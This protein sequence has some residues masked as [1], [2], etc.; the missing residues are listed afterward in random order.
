MNEKKFSEI[1]TKK[2][3]ELELICAPLKSDSTPGQM[4]IELALDKTRELYLWMAEHLNEKT[5]SLPEV[6]P[7]KKEIPQKEVEKPEAIAK[8][9]KKNIPYIDV[10]KSSPTT[11]QPAKQNITEMEPEEAPEIN[12]EDD[13]GFVTA[14]E[15]EPPLRETKKG[16][17]ATIGDKFQNNEKNFV[18]ENLGKN[19]ENKDL[20]SRLQA[21]PITD[22]RASIGINEKFLF[23]KEL[24]KGNSD[25][26]SKSIDFLNQAGSI[27]NAMQYIH[28]NFQWD[29]ESETTIKFLDLVNRKF[30]R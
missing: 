26:Y 25:Y 5:D 1:L 8:E 22:L 13:I 24:F 29:K 28:E 19:K 14:P 23:I 21:K 20:T 30:R 12:N 11:S 17:K 7:I 3:R 9:A 18:N 27:D 2:L 16:G 4:D 10:T 15:P 6:Q